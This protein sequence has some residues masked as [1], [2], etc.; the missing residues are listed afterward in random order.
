MRRGPRTEPLEVARILRE[1][2]RVR[3][4]SQDAC[5]LAVG[6]PGVVIR[7]PGTAEAIG[8]AVEPRHAFNLWTGPRRRRHFARMMRWCLLALA[9]LLPGWRVAAQATPR[10]VDAGLVDTA[11]ASAVARLSEPGGFFDSDNLIS[12][13]TSYLHVATRLERDRVLGGG[14]IG[15]GPDQNFSYIA[16]VRPAVAYLLDIRRDNMLQHLM[17]K[18]L[19]AAS[20]NRMEFL[21]RWLGRTPPLDLV[22]WT[23]R[24]LDDLLAWVGAAPVDSAWQRVVSRQTLEAV[25]RF[26]VPLDGRD[27]DVLTRFHLEFMRR[28]LQLRFTSFGRGDDPSRPTLRDLL[29]ATDLGGAPRSFL[30]RESDWRYVRDLHA[31]G[32]IIP[33]V[34]DLAGPRALAAI[35]ADLRRRGVNL[36]AIYTSNAEQYAWRDGGF[37]AFAASLGRFPVDERSVVIRSVFERG[38]M[39]HPL[40]VPG[41]RSVQALQRVQDFT[42]RYRAGD[43]RSY[44]DLVTLDAR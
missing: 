31:A 30:V 35:A 20:S 34:G 33:V 42:R 15:V 13:E 12:N 44:G 29:R 41:H 21:C 4:P 26:G 8:G 2:N 9:L 28:G 10:R 37:P 23:G 14:Y 18:A 36:T 32:R 22:A 5:R 16:I 3:V 43:I 38:G 17:Y 40:A 7:A 25:V 1:G 6:G 39:R 19:F 11:F 24:P 27:R